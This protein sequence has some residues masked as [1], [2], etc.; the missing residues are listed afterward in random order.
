[1]SRPN[2]RP[3]APTAPATNGAVPH[4]DAANA[5]AANAAAAAAAAVAAATAAQQAAHGRPQPVPPHGAPVPAGNGSNNNGYDGWVG[6]S[7]GC[8]Q[9]WGSGGC[10]SGA[11]VPGPTPGQMRNPCTGEVRQLLP[12]VE[13][14]RPPK[15]GAAAAGGALHQE[16]WMIVKKVTNK[17]GGGGAATGTTSAACTHAG[18]QPCQRKRCCAKKR[19][20][21][22]YRPAPKR[23]N[24]Y[25]ADH[26]EY[27]LAYLT[28]FDEVDLGPDVENDWNDFSNGKDF[29]ASDGEVFTNRKGISLVA[30]RFT[31]TYPP[32][33]V[34]AS[35]EP[36][37]TG[38]LDHLK[39]WI[40]RNSD[41][42]V[43]PCGQI[44]VEACIA[45]KVIGVED[46][47]APVGSLQTADGTTLD[48]FGS[49]VNNPHADLRLGYAALTLTD[50]SSG[51]NAKVAFTN[52]AIWAIYEMLPFDQ[53]D[54]V[55]E[56]GSR[57][58]FAGAFFMGQRNVARPN[59][60]FAK[61]GIA[62]DKQKGLT[63]YLNGVPVHNE[64]RPGHPPKHDH[65]L[66]HVPGESHDVEVECLRFGL[67]LFTM[68]DALPMETDKISPSQQQAL[69]RL[70][71]AAYTS[72][73]RPG[74]EVSFVYNNSPWTARLPT[75]AFMIS[76]E[77][78]IVY[79]C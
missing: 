78:K 70:S 16:E 19:H 3:Y 75:G 63:W 69:V 67:G 49:A 59:S 17:R 55:A 34:D 5:A 31:L 53:E 45:A 44:Y 29:H 74:R 33:D 22:C 30:K 66:Y 65:I 71:P 68:L 21:Q 35:A 23:E 12:Y 20:T 41:Y 36:H 43:P 14:P 37:P 39:R 76:K 1:M 57:A 72:P 13:T 56:N 15:P 28:T 77:F 11:F 40:I 51:L 52:E 4:Q 62:Y 42:E 10:A 48:T 8:A 32:P 79:R 6:P 60:D 47:A 7:N 24:C 18:L 2:Y 64:P 58:S 9:K 46:A 73:V 27:D 26:Q 38:F 25:P 50:F 61:V 54:G